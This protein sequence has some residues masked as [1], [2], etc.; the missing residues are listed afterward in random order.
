[1]PSA[2]KMPTTAVYPNRRENEDKRPAAVKTKTNA[3]HWE[4][5]HE[6]P[7]TLGLGHCA[8]GHANNSPV[9]ESFGYACGAHCARGGFA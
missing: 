9:T 7:A 2:A 4:N 3:N 1:M 8:Q 6:R 5:K